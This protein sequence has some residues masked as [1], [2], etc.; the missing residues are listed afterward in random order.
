MVAAATVPTP[1]DVKPTGNSASASQQPAIPG[2]P[3]SA[4]ED[5]AQATST[6]IAYLDAL[7]AAQYADAWQLLSPDAQ[8]QDGS[9]QAFSSERAAFY[10]QAGGEYT[11]SAPDRTAAAIGQW[12]PRDF[13]GDTERAS[14]LRVD[15]PALSGNNAGWEM[16]VVAPD[17][18]GAWRIWVAR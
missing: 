14:V 5:A 18:D 16:F 15:H 3:P 11:L 17:V 4:G 9:L 6:A 1:A 2:T 7:V 10:A 8:R 13:H 12:L